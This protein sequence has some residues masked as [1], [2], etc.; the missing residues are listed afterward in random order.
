M[1]GV[2]TGHLELENAAGRDLHTGKGKVDAIHILGQIL[3]GKITRSSQAGVG[4]YKHIGGVLHGSQL[5][6]I[7][8][9]KNSSLNCY[10]AISRLA[11]WLILFHVVL[12][13]VITL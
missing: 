6:L 13:M 8:H 7:R 4:E 1:L 10:A 2:I 3:A 12:G 11:L 9:N 5:I